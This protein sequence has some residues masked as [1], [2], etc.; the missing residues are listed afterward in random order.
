MRPDSVITID[1]GA[2][3]AVAVAGGAYRILLSGAHTNGACA[4][5]EMEVPPHSG[6]G[7]HAHKDVQ[8]SFYVLE[9]EVVVRSE[10]Q[11]YTA[12]KGAFVNIPFGGAVHNFR[13]ES[14]HMARLLCIVTP[15]GMD[16]M[17]REIGKPLAAGETPPPPSPPTPEVLAQMKVIGEKYGQEF[18]PPDYFKK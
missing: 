15:A 10:T 5:I 6:P 8:E 13:N 1:P 12:R 4:V 3:D 11:T 14:D 17:F 9:G 16:D 18:F 7:P 2:G